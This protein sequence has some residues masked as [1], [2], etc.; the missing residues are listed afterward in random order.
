MG[1]QPD[2]FADVAVPVAVE[3]LFC[4]RIPHNIMEMVTPGC[5]VRIPFRR[6]EVLGL[7]VRVHEDP[8]QGLEIRDILGLVHQE[9]LLGPIQMRFLDWVSR[10]YL[11]PLG[12]VLKCALPPPLWR[13]RSKG[14][15]NPPCAGAGP[16][17]PS[18]PPSIIIA[19]LTERGLEEAC[20]PSGRMGHVQRGVLLMLKELG[21]TSM[22]DLQKMVPGARRSLNGL[23]SRGLLTWKLDVSAADGPFFLPEE[24]DEL[25]PLN[26]HQK[27]AAAAIEDA[28][29]EGG[30]K[31]FLLW[32][33]TASGKTEIY[34]RAV[35]MA[36]QLGR[37][38]LIMV[39]EI[40][41]THQMIRRFRA[42]FGECLSILH[43]RLSSSERYHMWWLIRSGQ[44]P[45]VIGARS[46]LF[47]P[48]S[49]P[50]V[51]IVDEEH[52]GSYKQ[53]EG[54]RYNARDGALML[55]KL[56]NAVVI[57]GSATPSLESLHNSQRGKIQLLRLPHRVDG[58]ALP[59]IELV[60]MRRK[61]RAKTDPREVL[62]RPLVEAMEETLNRREQVLL[63]LNRRGY[64]TFLICKGCGYVFGCSRCAVTLVYH[65]STRRLQ[66][67]YCGYWI[68]APALCPNCKGT[69]VAEL[70][71]GTETLEEV[72]Q[73]LFP[74]SRILRMD[75]DTTSR[76]HTSQRILREWRRG[77]ANVL[78]GTQMV[79][80]GH[81]VPNVTLVG[82]VMADVALNIPDF[83][84][85]ERT[86]QLLLQVA[87]RAGRGERP[88]RVIVQ[89]YHPDHPAMIFASR[90]DPL[91]FWR[92]LM[93]LR[94]Q[95]GYPPFKRLVLFL[96]SSK[97]PQDAQGAAQVLGEFAQKTC[98]TEKNVQCL[99][100]VPA[101]IPRLKG[102]FR[103][104]L[105]L[106]GESISQ[107]HIAARKILKDFRMEGLSRRVKLHVDV[108]PYHFL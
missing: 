6:K 81:H 104:Q 64:S 42:R 106:K 71:V 91:S 16:S 27:E 72:V 55:G 49:K 67:H 46:A 31:G 54:V 22:A 97:N 4:Y 23:I 50:G 12:M 56:S 69:D 26:D 68:P 29:R 73:Q 63:F 10:Y 44:K 43:S 95:A 77:E 83:R 90:D 93:E 5:Q 35:Q 108:D 19:A 33:V 18:L 34:L 53:Q 65:H 15:F 88:G 17:V 96:I 14:G 62:S 101:P 9:P 1:S 87:G 45:I 75:R 52:D 80:K 76:K 13:H 40:S 102:R 51:I 94:R 28:M 39:P 59:R 105:L 60:D 61:N 92:S 79:A 103:W 41:L 98:E 47:A 32:G 36:M 74:T 30:Y 82:V 24:G 37:Q 107:L 89:T 48:L 70:G 57:L 25:P 7:V 84:S 2:R 85:S 20:R 3:E 66:C 100:P 11:H 21:P 58:R 8:P 86:F 99:G 38:A 78:I